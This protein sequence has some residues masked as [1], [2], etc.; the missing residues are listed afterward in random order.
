M[1]K[2]NPVGLF[3]MHGNVF[4]WC[5][6]W[7]GEKLSGGTD[8]VGP[9][10]GSVQVVRGGGWRSYQDRCRSASRILDAP[11]ARNGNLGFRVACSPSAAGAERRQQVTQADAEARRC[12]SGDSYGTSA[13][14]LPVSPPLGYS[15]TQFN[16]RL[17]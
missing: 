3:D 12:Q 2:T 17:P 4:E 13:R 16:Q 9:G 6:D 5:S 14:R 1:K 10:G 15:D 7:Y 8:P 11:S